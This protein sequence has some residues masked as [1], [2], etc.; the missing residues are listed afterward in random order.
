MLQQI[1]D[2][3]ISPRIM[4]NTVHI[5]PVIVFLSLLIGARVAG[6]LGIFLAVPIAGVIVSWLEID[7][8]KAE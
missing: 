8:I 6:L 5:S 4:E 7:E 2:N 1:Q 3:L